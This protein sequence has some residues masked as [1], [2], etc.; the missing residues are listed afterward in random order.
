MYFTFTS[1]NLLDGRQ[2]DILCAFSIENYGHLGI[3][4]I[5]MGVDISFNSSFL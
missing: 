2:A 1:V 5:T 4:R 3:M